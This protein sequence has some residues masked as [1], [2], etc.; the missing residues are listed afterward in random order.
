MAFTWIVGKAFCLPRKDSGGLLL[1][2]CCLFLVAFVRRCYCFVF[3]VELAVVFWLQFS[4]GCAIGSPLL[5]TDSS[6]VDSKNGAA[7]RLSK[8]KTKPKRIYRLGSVA[9]MLQV[10]F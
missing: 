2:F 8:K 9:S 1:R 3:P 5:R 10:R 7:K 6:G 4:A